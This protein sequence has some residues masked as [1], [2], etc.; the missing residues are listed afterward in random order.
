MNAAQK[1]IPKKKSYSGDGKNLLLFEEEECGLSTSYT[2]FENT[3]LIET[4]IQYAK[5]TPQ[6]KK[7]YQYHAPGILKSDT[8]EDLQGNLYVTS[9]FF[10]TNAFSPRHDKLVY[11]YPRLPF[12]IEKSYGK[13]ASKVLSRIMISYTSG[14]R[15][16][17][18]EVFEDGGGL[19][20]SFKYSYDR[21]CLASETNILNQQAISRYDD[22]HNLVSYTDFGGRLTTE[23]NYDQMNRPFLSKE[24]GEGLTRALRCRYNARGHK[25]EAYDFYHHKTSYEYDALGNLL[26]TCLPSG[27]VIACE[28]DAS[29]NIVS[30]TDAKGSTTKTQYNV[31][32]KP[33]QIKHPNGH[34][35]RF[36][37]NKSGTLKKYIDQEGIETT[38]TYD[39]FGRVLTKETLGSKE[40]LTYDSFN[41]LSTTDAEG[42]VTTYTYDAL[43]RKTVEQSG[44]EALR[45]AYDS[46]G[47]LHRITCGEFSLLKAYNELG[48]LTKEEKVDALDHAF[49]CVTYE[50]DPLGNLIS[51]E[52]QVDGAF[53]KEHIEY[54]VFGRVKAKIDPGRHITTT[55]YDDPNHRQTTTDPLGLQTTQSFN[56]DN[57]ISCL[58]KHSPQGS[59]LLQELYSYDLNQNLIQ[60]KVISS[61]LSTITRWDYNEMDELIL[62]VEGSNTPEEK[63]THYSY[64]PKG[65]LEQIVKPNGV[66]INHTYSP[67]GDLETQRS[68]DGTISYHYVHDKN[69]L[70]KQATDELTGATI[71]RSYTPQGRLSKETLPGGPKNRGLS[72]QS[73]YDYMGRRRLLTLPDQSAISY[74]YDALYL[75]SVSRV[76]NN[77]ALYSHRYTSYDHAGNLLHEIPITNLP[78]SHH[79]DSLGRHTFAQ[80][81][82]FSENIT[83]FDAAGNILEK[84]RNQDHLSYTYD[85]LYQ[86]TSEKNHTYDYDSLHNRLNKDG[87]TFVANT[88]NQTSQL[89]YD[90]NGNPDA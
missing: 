74:E 41:I 80:S 10:N 4:Q 59:L 1:R 13:E 39:A 34:I 47:R 19:E 52:R 43:G 38:Y 82:Y 35:E 87:N 77:Q 2:Y 58:E 88:L 71:S 84:R 70:L 11:E 12:S 57:K 75:R 27:G 53:A 21:G 65:L 36:I 23:F 63:R 9:Y 17:K 55:T 50:Y 49:E 18:K 6:I 90:S 14:G 20:S 89:S 44:E 48:Q 83:A 8:I 73:S 40:T 16:L 68:S 61:D 25:V 56:A 62:L 7:H 32:K 42:N 37:Y 31:Y 5:G 60:K 72:F 26:K 67:L 46:Y 51:T 66:A 30:L 79:Y 15:V 45:Y 54:D 33:T 64:T 3:P 29:G 76:K 24:S 85:P 78:L 28:Y 81:H 22:L 69:S 86:L